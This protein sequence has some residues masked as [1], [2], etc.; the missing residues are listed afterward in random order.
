MKKNLT[1]NI[2]E[3]I[4]YCN[5]NEVCRITGSYSTDMEHND[6]IINNLKNNVRLAFEYITYLKISQQLPLKINEA[7]TPVLKCLEK[8]KQ[9]IY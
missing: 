7:F 9:P 3:E 8:N 5:R 4:N 6:F 2:T 1:D